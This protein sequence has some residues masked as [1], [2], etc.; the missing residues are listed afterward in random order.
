MMITQIMHRENLFYAG[1]LFTMT[2]KGNSTNTQGGEKCA[3]IYI[4]NDSYCFVGY[5]F[6]P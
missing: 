5:P 1:T 3:I 2:S 6:Y 4:P